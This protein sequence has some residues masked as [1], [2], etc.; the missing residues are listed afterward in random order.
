MLT[1][2]AIG[3]AM[4]PYL[5]LLQDHPATLPEALEALGAE[6]DLL[7]ALALTPQDP[8]WHGEGDVAAHVS[9]VLSELEQVLAETDLALG[10]P[11]R[12]TLRLAALLHDIG[13]PLCTRSELREG[14][15]RVVS[16]G[17]SG[18]GAAYL[19]LRLPGLVEPPGASL[20]FDV[21]ALV[22]RHH[23]PQSLVRSDAPARRFGR[24]GRAVD[25]RLLY[26]LCLA[27]ARGRVADD[28]A[29]LVERV[30]LFRLAC[31]EA[32]AWG[33]PERLA[34]FAR[35]IAAALPDAAEEALERVLFEGLW[36]LD[37]GRIHTAEEAVARHAHH[38][39]PSSRIW[40]TCGPSASGK[41]RWVQAHLGQLPVIEL[42]RLR[43]ALTGRRGEQRDNARVLAAA[44]DQL[45][46][47][48]RRGEPTVWEATALRR[49]QRLAVL[50]TARRYGAHTTLVV[51]CAPAP[52]LARRNRRRRDP[53]P[54]AVLE[55]Q[56]RV[57]EW[58]DENEAH[59]TLYVDGQGQVIRD[60]RASWRELLEDP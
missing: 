10:G 60:S 44:R 42:D 7:H 25:L 12:A 43:E 37:A 35:G 31:E 30:E 13:K 15:T 46:Q 19:A 17:H 36:D 3:Q 41:S 22:R 39:G 8:S 14:G 55:R 11:E 28:V 52:E 9:L 20:Y 6:I 21:L 18:R 47:R 50:E 33:G 27:D 56:L 49:E 58:P 57:L 26:L 51:F 2:D 48:L 54:D 34:G 23:R 45:R 38:A 24:L 5:E 32:R 1:Q 4:H 59:R 29:I 40:L 53:V 16:P